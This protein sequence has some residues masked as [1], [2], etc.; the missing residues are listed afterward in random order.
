MHSSKSDLPVVGEFDTPLGH[1]TLR[2]VEWGAMNVALESFP[3]GTDTGPLFKGLPNDRCQCPH[4]GYV[5]SGRFRVFFADRE[6][7]LRTGDIYYLEPGHVLVY[8]EPTDL[9]EFSPRGEYQATMEVAA[10]NLMEMLAGAS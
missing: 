4:W 1:V 6:E 10:Q 3:A 9:K 2:E 5:V 7:T 8:D